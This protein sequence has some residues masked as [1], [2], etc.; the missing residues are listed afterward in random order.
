MGDKSFIKKYRMTHVLR[1]LYISG[2]Q[3]WDRLPDFEEMELVMYVDPA[4]KAGK[5]NDILQSL[6]LE[7]NTKTK[8]KYVV[9]AYTGCF[10]MTCSSCHRKAYNITLKR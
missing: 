3:Y 7:S 4:I 5:R 9:D 2:Y 6:S 8:Q 1:I 10:P